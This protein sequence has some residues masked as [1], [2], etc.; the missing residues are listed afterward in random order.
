MRHIDLD[1][2]QAVD[3]SQITQLSRQWF[4]EVRGR[5]RGVPGGV[6]C[7]SLKCD[8]CGRNATFIETDGPPEIHMCSSLADSLTALAVEMSE[9]YGEFITDVSRLR[10]RWI[11]GLLVVEFAC[12]PDISQAVSL[13]WPRNQPASALWR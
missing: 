8:S 5:L 13:M 9:N 10:V 4:A 1:T 12:G 7:R 6:Q 3:L 2:V 11:R